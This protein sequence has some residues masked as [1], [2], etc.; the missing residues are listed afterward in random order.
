[1]AIRFDPLPDPDEAFGAELVIAFAP[2]VTSAESTPQQAAAESAEP[3]QEAKPEVEE[4][5]S[6]ATEEP[7]LP[8]E[9]ASPSEAED[10][11]LRMARE[12]TREESET[13]PE[14]VQATEAAEAQPPVA[15]S[16]ASI[17]AE[18]APEQRAEQ[19][20]EVAAA[21]E[22]G[23]ARDAQRRIEAWQ[24][25]IFAHIGRFKTYPEAAR[26]RNIRGEIVVAFTLDRKGGVSGVRIA[27]G[28]GSSILDQAALEV[29]RKANPLPAPPGEV[30][31]EAVE[32]LLPMRYQLR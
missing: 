32:L 6:S 23:N 25:A 17:A 8:T 5:K 31:G 7:D 26:K 10:P 2:M 21:P 20:S 30:R 28:S 14:M 4:V 11:A 22:H 24:R 16:E 29:L 15:R 27:I 3:E 13:A 12:R 19:P 9:Q 1:M 18:A